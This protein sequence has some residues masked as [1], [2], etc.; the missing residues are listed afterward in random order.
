[1]TKRDF[2]VYGKELMRL[3]ECLGTS[4]SDLL[5]AAPFSG[6]GFKRT[7]E[8]DLPRTEV[9]YEF[10]GHHV[11][12]TCD[13]GE[14]VRTIFLHAGVDQSLSGIPFSMT[15]KEVLDRFGAPSA[16]GAATQHPVLGAKGAWD[17][18][19]SG[20]ITVHVQY[21]PDADQIDLITLMCPDAVPPSS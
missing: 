21:R 17:R 11:D 18:F 5:A 12:V 19:S 9:W 7:V 3:S 20:G 14:S 2:A 16:S 13:D 6:W 1:M 4:V 10:E 15:R 8:R